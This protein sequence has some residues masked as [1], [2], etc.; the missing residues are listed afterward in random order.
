M[1]QAA[2]FI[3]DMDGTLVDNMGFHNQTW[4]DLLAAEGIRMGIEE[5]NRRTAGKTTSEILR[6]FFSNLDDAGI[7]NLAERKETI[8]RAAYRPHIKP[9]A[10]LQQFLQETSQLG[11]RSAL[12]TSASMQNIDFALDGIGARSF[13]DVIVSVE[14]V[15]H[16]KPDPEMFLM[17]ARRLETYPEQ[18]LVFEDSF[19]GLEAAHRAGM[20]AIAVA[21]TLT[22]EDLL[23]LSGVLKVITDYAGIHP[24]SLIAL[25]KNASNLANR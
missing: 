11:V 16:S 7:S 18:C 15:T 10:G 4:V 19:A 6:L 23:P 17:A 2:A 14:D 25:L 3:F 9:I 24:Q 13:F 20:K 1:N 8:Y 22:P 5:F 21:S 12:A